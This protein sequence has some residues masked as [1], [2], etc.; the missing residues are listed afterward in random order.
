MPHPPNFVPITAM[1][2]FAGLNFKNKKLA[3]S[4]PLLA[5]IISDLFL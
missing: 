2:L 1:A 4:I 5:M 3:Y